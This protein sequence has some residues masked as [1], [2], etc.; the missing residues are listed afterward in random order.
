MLIGFRPSQPPAT[1][2][3]CCDFRGRRPGAGVAVCRQTPCRRAP[4]PRLGL[5]K[6]VED[7]VLCDL[8][9]V[10]GSMQWTHTFKIFI[11]KQKEINAFRRT[12]LKK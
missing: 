5:Q 8:D 11:E 4:R 9:S 10:A 7:L 3:L 2:P 1:G 12:L 6:A